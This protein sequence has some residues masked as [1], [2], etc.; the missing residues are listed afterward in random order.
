VRP[1]GIIAGHDYI[2]GTYVN[3]EFGVRSAVDDFFA[4]LSLRARATFTDSP[5]ISWFVI[6]P[7]V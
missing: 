3:G 7:S 5:W 1:T 4:T 6:V 2:D